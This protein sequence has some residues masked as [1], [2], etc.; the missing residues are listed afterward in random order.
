MTTL[1]VLHGPNLNLLGTREPEIYGDL[2]LAEIDQ[3]LA[4]AASAK[5]VEI[6]SIQSNSEGALVDAL[7][8]AAKK[9]D[10]VIFN[11]AGYTHT[12][13][14]LRDAVAA[15]GIPVIEVHLSNVYAREEFRKQSL[16]APVCLGKITGFGWMSYRLALEALIERG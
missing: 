6:Y 9:A 12:S 14:A 7:Q 8:E 11:P 10:G 13:V 16:I 2:T 4:E 1:L 15:I 5:D 3:K